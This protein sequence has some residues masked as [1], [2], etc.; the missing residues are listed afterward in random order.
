MKLLFKKIKL[1][2]LILFLSAYVSNGSKAEWY[3]VP[4]EG[5]AENDK[6]TINELVLAGHDFF[7]TASEGLA[8]AVETL[9]ASLGRPDAY[10]VG[11]EGSGAFLA[12]LTYGEGNISTKNQG[13]QKIYW[14]GP[15]IGFDYG[16]DGSR[17]MILVYNLNAIDDMH[18]RFPGT[19]GTA[20]MVG[21][22]GGSIF[23][24]RGGIVVATIKTG[25]GLR[26]GANIGYIKFSEEPKWFPF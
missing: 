5:N 18:R 4:A 7:G 20:Y 16:G 10:I 1:F 6:F 12:G 23:S 14:Q 2:I 8:T 24:N 19:N 25:V 11:E 13:D 17:V 26:L 9:T 3:D 22:L 21:G 15:S